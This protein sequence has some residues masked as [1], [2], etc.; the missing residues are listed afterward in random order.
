MN[1]K[2][3]YWKHGK[4]G[5]DQIINPFTPIIYHK[6]EKEWATDQFWKLV[7]TQH[8]LGTTLVLIFNRDYS[9][10]HMIAKIITQSDKRMKKLVQTQFFLSFGARHL[11]HQ[12]PK[13]RGLVPISSNMKPTVYTHKNYF[14][15]RDVPNFSVT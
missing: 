10:A 6:P 2:K 5:T 13:K 9:T 11:W 3:G 14:T 1:K 15:D 7:Y 8:I 12:S 4:H